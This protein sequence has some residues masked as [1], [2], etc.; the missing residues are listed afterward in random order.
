MPPVP[1]RTRLKH[2]SSRRDLDEFAFDDSHTREIEQKRN[3]GQISCAECRRLKIKCDK[4]IPCQSCRV[5]IN[6]FLLFSLALLRQSSTTNAFHS[7]GVAQHYVPMEASPQAK[8][9]GTT[10]LWIFRARSSFKRP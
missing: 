9:L 8:E 6:Y 5:G 7:G 10:Y 4:Q 3:S 1:T 2:K